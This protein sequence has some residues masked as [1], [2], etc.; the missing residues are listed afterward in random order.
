[1][2]VTP[3]SPGV[4]VEEIPSGVRTI[5][6]VATSITAF[7]GR[8]AR[9][10]VNEATTI[11]NFGDFERIFGG[12]WAES[13]L[14]YTVRDFYLNGGS[15]AVIVRLFN[16]SEAERVSVAIVAKTVADATAGADV[17]AAKKGANDAATAIQNDAAKSDA[18]KK[19]AKA[20]S[21]AVDT[22]AGTA[23]ATVAD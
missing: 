10:P 12:L 6:G 7:V 14:G 20:V 19:A 4:Y 17:A 15:Q 2:P 8:A 16:P 5:V 9:G 11:N 3:T 23:G 1:M 13:K 18:E 21:D 22:A